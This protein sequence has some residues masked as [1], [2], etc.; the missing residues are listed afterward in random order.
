MVIQGPVYPAGLGEIYERL[1]KLPQITLR[2]TRKADDGSYL[3]DVSLGHPTP[4]V[5]I[6]KQMENVAEVSVGPQP[7]GDHI[8]NGSEGLRVWRNRIQR[9][10]QGSS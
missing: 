3:F 6:L 9:Q 1:V 5:T 8:A 10:R 7:V 4:L 2:D